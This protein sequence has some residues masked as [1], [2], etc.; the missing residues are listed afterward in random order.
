MGLTVAEAVIGV[1]VPAD[2]IGAGGPI[3]GYHAILLHTVQVKVG[4]IATLPA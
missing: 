1:V 2:D 4:A 3:T